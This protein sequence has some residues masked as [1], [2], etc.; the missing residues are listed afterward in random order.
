MNKPFVRVHD[1]SF[2]YDPAKPV[3][4]RVSLVFDGPGEDALLGPSGCGKKTLLRL[5]AGLIAPTSGQIERSP[6]PVA[7]CFQEDRLLPWYTVGQNV[8]LALPRD[9]QRD[10]ERAARLAETWLERVGLPD[11]AHM[12]PSE[13]SGGMKRRASLARALAYDAPI[14]MMDEP[15]RA[16][17]E[18]AHADMLRLVRACAQGRLLLL[19]THDERD[20][21]GMQAVRL[22]PP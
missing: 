8:A 9:V 18:Q 16:L 11:V 19:V 3:L 15:F 4:S 2:A 7:F 14:L 17:D 21:S 5:C 12:Y 22:S 6:G 13:L 20:S 1:V 10:R